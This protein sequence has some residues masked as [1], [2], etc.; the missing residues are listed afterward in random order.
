[1][2][3]LLRIESR[4]ARLRA[5]GQR[6]RRGLSRAS[7]ANG[8]GVLRRA[9]A[10]RA[11]G[12]WCA[13]LTPSSPPRP[14]RRRRAR[15]S[16]V[17]CV[18]RASRPRVR[19]RRRRRAAFFFREVLFGSR[20]RDDVMRSR[21]GAAVAALGFETSTSNFAR[22]VGPQL[23]IGRDRRRRYHRSRRATGASFGSRKND[24]CRC[25]YTTSRM[26]IYN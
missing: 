25:V 1:M 4:S 8:A 14:T 9:R 3:F 26:N 5:A 24:L 22:E 20:T 11:D 23:E 12:R 16:R 2:R 7:D 10:D 21:A 19:N 18:R 17:R 6:A 13:A 15:R